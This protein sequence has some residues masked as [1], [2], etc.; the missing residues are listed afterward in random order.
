[1]PISQEE[2]VLFKKP[3]ASQANDFYKYDARKLRKYGID[4]LLI[5][6][7]QYG[8]MVNYYGMIETGKYGNC[9]I[10][11]QIVNLDDNTIIYENRTHKPVL[12]QGKWKT[13]PTYNNL[14]NAIDESI[15]LTLEEEKIKL[16]L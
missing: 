12:I 13:P 11:T 14:K 3:K 16:N 10:T 5:V 1:M 15:E 9:L 7:V 2:F 6:H 8:L 4:E